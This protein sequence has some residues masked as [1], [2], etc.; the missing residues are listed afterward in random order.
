[1]KQ[2]GKYNVWINN[3]KG[4]REVQFRARTWEFE[5]SWTRTYLFR[6]SPRGRDAF[7]ILILLFCTPDNGILENESTSFTI[8][9]SANFTFKLRDNDNFEITELL[10]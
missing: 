9:L 5:H 10:C 1:M 8:P 2:H 3:L 4:K 7:Y 6:P